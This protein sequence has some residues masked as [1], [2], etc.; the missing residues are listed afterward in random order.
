[1]PLLNL[2]DVTV[3]Y[4]QTPVLFNVDMAVEK[5]EIACILGR[6]GVGKT[7]LLRSV[8]GLNKVS[9]GSIIFDADEITKTPTYLRAR[10][11][12]SLFPRV[13]R[14]FPICPCWII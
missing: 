7:T 3:S 4:G 12:I 11:G 2:S 10:Y 9:S 8:I 6:N 5:G 14:L 13:G 1:M